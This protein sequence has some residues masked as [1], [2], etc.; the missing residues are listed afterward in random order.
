MAWPLAALPVASPFAAV[1]GST[2]APSR[3]RGDVRLDVRGFGA[4][5][6]GITDDTSSFQ[7]AIEALP[8]DGGTLHV[9][10]GNYAIDATRNVRLRSR[11]LLELAPDA[12]L[13]AIPNDAERAYVVLIQDASDVEVSGG[14][15]RGERA[16][17]L[18]STG[19][20][21][22]GLTVR[23]ASRVS[24]HDIRISDCWGD[25]ISIGSNPSR[26]GKVVAPSEDVVVSRVTCTNNRRQGLTIGRSRRVQVLDSEFS[27]TAGTPPAAGIDIEPD[28]GDP[29]DNTGTRDVLILR[30][31]VHDNHGPGI[32]IFKRARGVRIEQCDLRDN[33]NGGVLAV[34]AKDIAIVSNRMRGNRHQDVQ[35]RGGSSGLLVKGNRFDPGRPWK[36]SVNVAADTA[37]ATLA[38]DNSNN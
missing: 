7:R 5:G 29:P 21:G 31:R 34:S 2:S 28:S 6:D 38:G 36:G 3:Q 9:P 12:V 19:E 23:G 26:P 33:G 11:M 18:G 30:C 4:V 22:H 15:I 8:A 14:S 17:H 16:R 25:G 37:N 1:P 20:W 10:A 35:V 27:N 32:Q 13:V 24:I